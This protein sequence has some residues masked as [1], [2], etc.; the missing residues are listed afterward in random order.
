MYHLAREKTARVSHYCLSVYICVDDLVQFSLRTRKTPAVVVLVLIY[1]MTANDLN[2]LI[3]NYLNL[4]LYLAIGRS[5]QTKEHQ[6]LQA[7]CTETRQFIQI[8]VWTTDGASGPSSTPVDTRFFEKSESI[9][10][11][12]TVS[13]YAG[14]LGALSCSSSPLR[15]SDFVLKSMLNI[16]ECFDPTINTHH[17]ETINK[18]RGGLADILAQTKNTGAQGGLVYFS[19]HSS[20]Y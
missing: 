6:R 5:H 4:K 14:R 3:L 12:P 19:V 20:V 11:G 2:S 15:S 8:F 10:R 9:I 16:F 13:M 7:V 18:L 17:N 1:R